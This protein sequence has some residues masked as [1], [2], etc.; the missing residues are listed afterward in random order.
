MTAFYT[1]EYELIEDRWTIAKN[2]MLSWFFIDVLAIFPFERIYAA[3]NQEMATSNNMNDMIRLARLGRLYKILRLMR[4]FRVLKLGKSSR[5]L[6]KDL[7]AYFRLGPGFERLLIFIT[8][9]IIVCH[10]VTC[11]WIIIA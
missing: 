8:C 5:N 6:I 2:Y 1:D 7:K 9:F 3:D 4:L 10:I 11:L